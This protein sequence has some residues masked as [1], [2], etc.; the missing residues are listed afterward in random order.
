[1]RSWVDPM[2]ERA[3]EDDAAWLRV[4]LPELHDPEWEVRIAR[5]LN[6]LDAMVD[7]DLAAVI[8]ADYRDTWPPELPGR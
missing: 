2:A 4:H 7:R 5:I 3:Y 6:S 1:M 8:A